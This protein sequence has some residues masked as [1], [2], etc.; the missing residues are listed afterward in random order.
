[1][2]I[3]YFNIQHRKSKPEFWLCKPDRTSIHKIIDSFDENLSI[4]FS[5]INELSFSIP[6]LVERNHKLIKNPLIDKIKERYLI[7]MKK[8]IK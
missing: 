7:R 6:V 8:I 5:A 2:S 3:S 1:M 4:K